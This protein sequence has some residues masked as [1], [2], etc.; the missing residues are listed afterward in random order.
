MTI[1]WPDK[2]KVKGISVG[3]KGICVGKWNDDRVAGWN[4]ALEACKE[5]V[6]KAQSQPADGRVGWN[7]GKFLIKSREIWNDEEWSLIRM[8][9]FKLEEEASKF[10]CAVPSEKCLELIEEAL[11]LGYMPKNWDN[12][13]QAIA[14]LIRGEK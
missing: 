10:T 13:A 5:V 6:E 2:K 4:D 8:K 14:R 11:K 9:W 12:K 7:I 3:G 1:E